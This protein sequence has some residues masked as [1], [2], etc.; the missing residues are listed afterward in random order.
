[1]VFNTLR[2]QILV[3]MIMLEAQ[4][5]DLEIERAGF[6]SLVILPWH[7]AIPQDSREIY[8]KLLK[9]LSI[10]FATVKCI[11]PL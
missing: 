9:R 5:L 2:Y 8:V 1:M 7:F 4:Y 11:S 3:I 10:T 6:F